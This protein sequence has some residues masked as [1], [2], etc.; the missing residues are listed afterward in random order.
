V[1]YSMTVDEFKKRACGKKI[2]SLTVESELLL[3]ELE[4]DSAFQLCVNSWRRPAF[5]MRFR[6]DKDDPDG[7]PITVPD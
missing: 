5:Y 2:V 6:S 1:S 3:I 7:E 4:D